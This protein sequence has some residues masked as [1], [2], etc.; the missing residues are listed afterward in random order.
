VH[1]EQLEAKTLRRLW[2]DREL[3]GFAS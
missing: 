1:K 3:N 2:D